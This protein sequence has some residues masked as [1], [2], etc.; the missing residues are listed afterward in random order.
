MPI[1]NTPSELVKMD[2]ADNADH[3]TF[4]HTRDTFSRFP[5]II[6]SGAK[7]KEGQTAE[8]VKESVIS[9]WVSFFGAPE[10]TMADKD[11]RFTG[12]RGFFR[13]F[14]PRVT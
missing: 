5:A 12:E 14:A 3:S 6:F 8:M 1:S 9:E 4:L 7:M 13:I 11:P 10:I 2:F